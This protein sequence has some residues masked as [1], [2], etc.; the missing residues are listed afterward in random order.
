M[1]QQVNQQLF[2]LFFFVASILQGPLLSKN[3]AGVTKFAE[4]PLFLEKKQEK[5]N[6][7]QYRKFNRGQNSG[8]RTRN[9]P[10]VERTPAKSVRKT[11]VRKK[12]ET[13]KKEENQEI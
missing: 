5:Q 3:F 10:P 8:T 6:R 11:N 2:F 4:F 9:I 1:E 13:K 7:L 12:G